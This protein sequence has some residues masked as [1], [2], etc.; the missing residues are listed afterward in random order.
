MLR[1]GG[2]GSKTPL[3]PP[4]ARGA[5]GMHCDVGEGGDGDRLTSPRVARRIWTA[6]ELKPRPAVAD[7]AHV[8]KDEPCR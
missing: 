6:R 1:G 7:G 5:P 2:G 3:A 8:A 4:P